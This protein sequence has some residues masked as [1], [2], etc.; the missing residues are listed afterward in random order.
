[1]PFDFKKEYRE[2]HKLLK[3]KGY[4]IL[5]KSVYL[6]VMRDSRHI[7][8]EM[9]MLEQNSPATGTVVAIQFGV[10]ELNRIRTLSGEAFDMK[11]FA[12][13]LIIV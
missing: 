3:N 13:S 1:M 10:N 11:Y 5:Q 4:V 8:S 9:R 2:F 6:K 12:D 7:K